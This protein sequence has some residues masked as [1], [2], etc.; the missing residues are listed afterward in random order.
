MDFSSGDGAE[1]DRAGDAVG[2][3]RDFQIWSKGPRAPRDAFENALTTFF[4]ETSGRAATSGNL[5]PSWEA[6]DGKEIRRID[7]T[8]NRQP[9]FVR[10][11]E[12]QSTNF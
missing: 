6:V 1:E 4:E 12:K 10:N 2:L 5:R 3:D 9:V 8:A 7:V 11:K